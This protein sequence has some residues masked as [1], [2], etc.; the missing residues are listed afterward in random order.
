[1]ALYLG[2][3]TVIEPMRAQ[4]TVDRNQGSQAV[5]CYAFFFPPQADCLAKVRRS[6]TD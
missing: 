1:M 4:G 5:L 2:G 3:E 6:A